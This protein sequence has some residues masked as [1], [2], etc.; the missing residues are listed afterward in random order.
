[1]ANPV[2]P[3]EH[4]HSVVIP[5]EQR[6]YIANGYDRMLV[7]E[8]SY[9]SSLR[10]AGKTAPAAAPIVSVSSTS[11]TVANGVHYVRY[12]YYDPETGYVSNASPQ[13]TISAPGNKALDV[14]T[15]A[16][17][18]DSYHGDKI[19][20]EMTAAGGTTFYEADEVDNASATNEVDIDDTTL[21]AATLEYD[22]TGHDM[23]PRGRCI[24]HAKGRMF[25]GGP[26]AHKIGNAT[27]TSGS[28][29]V[30]FSSA[31]VRSGLVDYKFHMDDRPQT[32]REIASITSAANNGKVALAAAYLGS[33]ASGTYVAQ[34]TP[35]AK[36][37]VYFSKA[38]YPEAFNVT[39]DWIRV[40]ENKGDV[41]A[42]LLAWRNAVLVFGSW[43]MELFT[44]EAD[45]GD[46]DDGRLYPVPG[47]RGALT[48]RVVVEYAGVAYSMDKQGIFAY[49]G[50]TL[51]DL[52]GAIRNVLKGINYSLAERF[53]AHWDCITKQYVVFVCHGKDVY[54]QTSLAYRPADGSWDISFYD[55]QVAEGFSA[56]LASGELW[57]HHVW[58]DTTIGAAHRGYADLVP[59]GYAAKGTVTSASRTS[60]QVSEELYTDMDNV[61][62]HWEEGAEVAEV[63][64]STSSTATMVGTG[65]TSAPAV[66][67]TIQ[68]GRIRALHRSRP[69]RIGGPDEYQKEI[70]LVVEFEPLISSH[71]L[72][73]RIYQDGA[74]SP[75]ADWNANTNIEGVTISTDNQ[76]IQIDLSTSKGFVEIPLGDVWHKSLVVAFE[77]RGGN[78]PLAM[79]GYHIEVETDELVTE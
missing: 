49:D 11:G 61:M 76:D 13:A 8:G 9:A 57:P 36:N 74:S 37:T 34:P 4:H 50:E 54:P 77:V 24:A 79:L 41:L 66:G 40:L 6:I 62:G 18:E 46:T 72:Y 32:V 2:Y 52:S 16:Q 43:S 42:A 75:K 73:C 69:F 21:A 23:P 65:F 33:Y 63:K 45:P 12:R 51:Q 20:I 59:P 26:A 47:N 53:H 27:T 5:A 22:A 1:M 14:P 31:D 15:T 38:L 44:W 19:M 78:V 64:S 48:Q 58:R 70:K 28:T 39:T 55:H 30:T 56:P 3:S 71:S 68:F 67:D 60:I 17:D 10:Y 29:A 7:H 35:A 25:I